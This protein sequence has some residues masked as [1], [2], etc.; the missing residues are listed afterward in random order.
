MGTFSFAATFNRTTFD[1][2]TTEFTFCKLSDIF[3]SADFG[4][5]DVIHKVSG[6][7]TRNS[8]LGECAVLIDAEKKLLVNLP[9]HL[10]KTAKTISANADA[11]NAIMAGKVG[12][13]VRK[14]EARGKECYTINFVDL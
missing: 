9:Q 5:S 2:N 4:G 12:Y 11:I 7:Y 14:Y 6:I 1:V 13:C 10:V 3:N 8:K